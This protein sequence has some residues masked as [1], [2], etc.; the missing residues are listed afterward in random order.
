MRTTAFA[1]L[2]LA[3]LVP[4]GRADDETEKPH[5]LKLALAPGPCEVRLEASVD[6]PRSPK[7]ATLDVL[8]VGDGERLVLE[9]GT[10]ASNNQPHTRI[11]GAERP[12]VWWLASNLDRPPIALLRALLP[13]KAV[14]RGEQWHA[15]PAAIARA[16][17]PEGAQVTSSAKATVT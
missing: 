8:L 17:C 6:T 11:T 10:F 3:L 15:D 1:A 9:E 7:L 2:T 16:L 12:A 14:A 13:A 5:E 4:P